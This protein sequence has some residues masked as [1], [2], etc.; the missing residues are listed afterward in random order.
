MLSCPRR[1]PENNIY[2]N[3][4]FLV[5]GADAELMLLVFERDYHLLENKNKNATVKVNQLGL[6]FWWIIKIAQNYEYRFQI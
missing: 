2:L 1:G 5:T 3:K 4:A 6:C